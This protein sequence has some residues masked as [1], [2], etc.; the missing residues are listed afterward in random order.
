MKKQ[1]LPLILC[2][3]IGHR[4]RPLS[5]VESPKQFI[6]IVTQYSL[7]QETVLRVSD[8][9]TFLHPTFATNSNYYTLLKQHLT[10]INC[11]YSNIILEPE[12][13]NTAAAVA[14][15]IIHLQHKYPSD[16]PVLILPTD[17]YIPKNCAFV[18]LVQ[19][20]VAHLSFNRKTIIAFGIHSDENQTQYGYIEYGEDAISEGESIYHVQKFVAK[21]D[22][23][24]METCT[25]NNKYFWNS[26]IYFATLGSIF[27]NL[28]QH[29][30]ILHEICDKA[31]KQGMCSVNTSN[32]IPDP[33]LFSLAEN[34]TIEKAI[35]EKT[36]NLLAHPLGMEW[37]DVGDWNTILKLATQQHDRKQNG[38]TDQ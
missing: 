3:G 14:V 7:L 13:K 38:S 35:M 9:S 5:S 22:K 4:L 10:G 30:P 1:V 17:H 34:T 2:G 32:L 31:I 19:Q 20:M 25:G 33:Y 15:A 37:E 8:A 18:T 36:R 12:Y 28:Q 21:P 6:P 27:R 29:A 11:K 24:V 26:G 16:T 23:E